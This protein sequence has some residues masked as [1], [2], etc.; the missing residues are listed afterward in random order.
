[1]VSPPIMSNEPSQNRVPKM[2]KFENSA[3]AHYVELTG[4]A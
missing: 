2:V 3:I 1:M 4:K